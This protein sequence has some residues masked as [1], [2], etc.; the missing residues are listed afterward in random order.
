MSVIGK[1]YGK[2]FLALFNKEVDWL[3]DDIR[4]VLLTGY[5]PDQDIEDYLNDVRAFEITGA[6]Y[7]ANGAALSGKTIA[8]TGAT[9]IIK[10]D[11]NDT[12]WASATI[13]ADVAVIVDYQ[14]AVDATSPLIGYQDST[15]DIVSTSGTWEI[16]W[17]ASGIIQITVG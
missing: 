3:D 17:N 6:G 16:V 9:N 13:T 11:A 15:T 4:A 7:T 12:Q 10:L 8:Y 5:S 14:T 1:L 2:I